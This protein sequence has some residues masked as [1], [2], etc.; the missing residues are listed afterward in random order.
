MLSTGDGIAVAFL[1][2][3][4]IVAMIKFW[5]PRK[6]NKNPGNP[7]T[8]VIDPKDFV[9]TILCDERSENLE[10]RI[11]RLGDYMKE[12]K[13]EIIAEIRKNKN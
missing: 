6:N 3:T 9:P 5:H 10:G 7:A 2:V 4:I 8:P 12:T 13:T 11:E 1:F